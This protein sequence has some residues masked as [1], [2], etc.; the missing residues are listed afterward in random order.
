MPNR[1]VFF[2]LCIGLLF[3]ATGCS[4]Q[5]ITGDVANATPSPA[6][7]IMT[8]QSAANTT[9]KLK[10][11][12]F[13]GDLAFKSLEKQCGFGYRYLGTP[14][15]KKCLEYLETEMKKYADKTILQEGKYRDLPFTNVIGVFYPEGKQAPA[16]LPV[17]IVSHWDTRPVADGPNSPAAAGGFR[18][19][20]KGWNRLAPILGANDGASGVAVILEL[21]RLLKEQRAKTGV[22]LV[23]V[24]GEDYGDFRGNNGEGD[25]VLLGSTLFAQ[26]YKTYPEI[27]QPAYGIL[28]DM[29]G[30]KNLVIP[31]EENSQ[32]FA[33]AANEKVFGTAQALGYG[34][35]FRFNETQSVEDDHIPLNRAGIPTIDL[36]HPLPYGDYALRGYFFWHTQSDVPSKCSAKSLKIVGETVAETLYR[37]TAEQ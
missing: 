34:E 17:L 20:E 29:I 12:V 19:G 27:G 22:I 14:G 3:V 5:S 6:A 11:P 23:L 33:A 26:K 16:K 1:Y 9:E 4:K 7:P 13:D 2:T 10:R 30:G 8:V 36:I 25:G 24:D 31:K 18:F 32:Q 28:L 35:V 37:E 15:H 21:A